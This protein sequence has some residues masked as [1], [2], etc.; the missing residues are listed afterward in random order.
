MSEFGDSLLLTTKFKEDS[1][2]YYLESVKSGRVLKGDWN[3]RSRQMMSM[4][5]YKAIKWR[6]ERALVNNTLIVGETG[7]GKTNVSYQVAEAIAKVSNIKKKPFV[8]IGEHLDMR[9]KRV[10]NEFGENSVII[11]EEAEESINRMR[12]MS[13]RNLGFSNTLDQIRK[14]NVHF[15]FVAPSWKKLDRDIV[16]SALHWLFTVNYNDTKSKRVKARLEYNC[17]NEALTEQAY[18]FHSNLDFPYLESAKFKAYES[19]IR[20]YHSERD[21]DCKQ[22]VRDWE[23][24]HKEE[25]ENTKALELAKLLKELEIELLEADKSFNNKDRDT[26]KIKEKYGIEMFLRGASIS[27][28]Q[29]LCQVGFNTAKGFELKAILKKKER[30]GKE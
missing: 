22:N 27:E 25:K 23:N 17:Q 28:V 1:W 6:F 11:V 26:I 19:V 7:S 18:L 4:G 21:L 9:I 2:F 29:S 16:S 5:F 3:Y 14:Y 8:T 13:N 10:L 12:S 15:V 24:K 30:E 20:K